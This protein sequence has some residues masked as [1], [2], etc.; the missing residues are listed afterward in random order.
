MSTRSPQ[1]HNT[2]PLGSARQPL[3]EADFA[4]DDLN[5][6]ELDSCCGRPT[7]RED[8]WG[9]AFLPSFLHSAV[10]TL[11]AAFIFDL[12]IH[13]EAKTAVASL[14]SMYDTLFIVAALLASIT[15]AVLM[16]IAGWA[17]PGSDALATKVGLHAAWWS[18][19]C[20]LSV[21]LLCSAFK[22]WVFV[23]VGLGGLKEG[24]LGESSEERERRVDRARQAHL[25]RE[26]RFF[27]I[28]S[29]PLVISGASILL[30]FC[31]QAA[32]ISIWSSNNMVRVQPP[33][34]A[35]AATQTMHH[36][37]AWPNAPPTP[38]LLPQA[39][40]YSGIFLCS[41]T[42]FL[43]VSSLAFQRLH[44]HAEGLKA[45]GAPVQLHVVNARLQQPR[46]RG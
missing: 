46:A 34:A 17:P 2:N 6:E 20:S 28:F 18:L 1:R 29:L 16:S 44:R 11:S 40:I 36:P 4:E 33:P 3:P 43:L 35:A 37:C 14:V 5:E 39:F 8:P 9:D 24:P 22:A 15:G 32:I 26:L 30:L 42:V 10:S 12:F 25:E 27:P 41:A 19:F 38:T 31:W 45:K 21:L 7:T 23:V 13:G